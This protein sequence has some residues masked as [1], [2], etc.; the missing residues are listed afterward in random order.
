MSSK[1][2]EIFREAYQTFK[3]L[4]RYLTSVWGLLSVFTLNSKTGKMQSKRN[5]FLPSPDEIVEALFVKSPHIC[6]NKAVLT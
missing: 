1:E 5:N 2:S 3:D 4:L 6:I